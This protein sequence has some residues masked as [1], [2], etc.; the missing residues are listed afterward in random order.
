[1]QEPRRQRVSQTVQELAGRRAIGNGIMVH[2]RTATYTDDYTLEYTPSPQ[3]R[4][5]FSQKCGPL[6]GCVN[7]VRNTAC[8]SAT[9]FFCENECDTASANGPRPHC[10]NSVIGVRT[11][12]NSLR[13]W[14][15]DGANSVRTARIVCDRAKSVRI[16]CDR[17]NNVRPCE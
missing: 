7:R 13:I 9:V 5:M 2:I 15:E 11:G 1:M 14:C 8:E 3:Y 16:V 10:A 12:A 4:T 6:D 17:A